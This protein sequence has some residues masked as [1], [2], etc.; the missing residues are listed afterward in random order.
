MNISDI[1]RLSQT[2]AL[3]AVAEETAARADRIIETCH[4]D[5]LRA[6]A[7]LGEWRVIEAVANRLAEK[8]ILEEMEHEAA[9]REYR[10]QEDREYWRCL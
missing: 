1:I 8:E 7:T 2:E 10:R 4:I 3:E 9:E 6:E 5:E